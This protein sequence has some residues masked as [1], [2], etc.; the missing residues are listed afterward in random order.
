ML[1]EEDSLLLERRL[2]LVRLTEAR[3]AAPEAWEV[4]LLRWLK[5]ADIKPPRLVLVLRA[6]PRGGL[7]LAPIDDDVDPASVL[8]ELWLLLWLWCVR[9]AKMLSE[10][11][12]ELRCIARIG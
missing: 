9:E 6:S 1:V 2:E 10:K 12:N 5:N 4:E 7:P 8:S 3:L 11:E